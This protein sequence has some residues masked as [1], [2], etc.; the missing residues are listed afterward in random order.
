VLIAVGLLYLLSLAVLLTAL[1]RRGDPWL[2]GLAPVGMLAAV[3]TFFGLAPE[4]WYPQNSVKPD[5]GPRAYT[6]GRMTYLTLVFTALAWLAH[7]TGKPW[8]LYYVVLWLVPLGTTYSFFML[9]RQV[10]QHGNGGQ[11]RLTNTRIFHVGRFIHFAVFPL[12]MDYHLPHHLF[13]MVP[14]YRLKQLHALLLETDDYR[15][16]APVV[17]GYFFP[18][19]VPPSH[20][21]VLDVMARP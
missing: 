14:H 2:L 4:R 13:P 6:L 9:L 16:E 7:L 1:V 21:T 8:G 5:V 12:G 15:R 3:L 17:E 20:P 10:V 11:G 19:E 18:R